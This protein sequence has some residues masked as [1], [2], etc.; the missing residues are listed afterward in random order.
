MRKP[1]NL[2]QYT[3]RSAAA[4]SL[5]ELARDLRDKGGPPLCHWTLNLHFWDPEWETKPKTR[6]AS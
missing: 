6:R 4:N 3:E 5:E 1:R 2:D